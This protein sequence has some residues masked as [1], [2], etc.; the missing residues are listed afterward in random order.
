MKK[1]IAFA[2]SQPNM[3]LI[4]VDTVII[5]ELV[6][7]IFKKDPI[8]KLAAFKQDRN[9][10]IS[11]YER[12]FATVPLFRAWSIYDPCLNQDFNREV[13]LETRKVVKLS[14]KNHFNFDQTPLLP[15]IAATIQNP[16][17]LVEGVAA[18][19]W[20]RGGLPSRDL[21]RDEDYINRKNV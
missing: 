10:R 5:V 17:N 21:T 4:M 2:T 18:A 1:P 9:V 19:G 20:I 14:L 16:H 13:I 8:Y 6:D 11:L 12:P 7:V 3:F 15:S